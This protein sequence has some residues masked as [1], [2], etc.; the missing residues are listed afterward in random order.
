MLRVC[1]AEQHW[2]VGNAFA[3][4]SA[5]VHWWWISAHLCEQQAFIGVIAVTQACCE[6]VLQSSIGQCGTQFAK[7]RAAVLLWWITARL[8]HLGKQLLHLQFLATDSAR[9]GGGVG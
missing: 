3:N 4:T 2:T 7:T 1:F 6:P 5:A 9:T 8:Q